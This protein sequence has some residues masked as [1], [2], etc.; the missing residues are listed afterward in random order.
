MS[1]DLQL[2]AVYN[3]FVRF[4]EHFAP[5]SVQ[6][7]VWTLPPL[8]QIM[9]KSMQQWFR[10]YKKKITT[11]RVRASGFVALS[12]EDSVLF[13]A[14][15]EKKTLIRPRLAKLSVEE[16]SRNEAELLSSLQLENEAGA[17]A[18]LRTK[19]SSTTTPQRQKRQENGAAV[20]GPSVHTSTARQGQSSSS[21][22]ALHTVNSKTVTG[23]MW[24]Y[25]SAC[26]RISTDELQSGLCRCMSCIL[27]D[28]RAENI[29]ALQ[30]YDALLVN[31]GPAK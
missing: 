28:L 9:Q 1:H 17:R 4:R 16:A 13:F 3:A 7:K 6:E 10:K 2:V 8:L 18:A 14:P 27:D 26:V 31:L 22:A 20:V 29:A 21:G 30:D 24:P 5:H 19:V 25:V 15:R 11:Q 12:E 23:E